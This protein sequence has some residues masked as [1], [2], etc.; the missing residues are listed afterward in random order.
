MAK[1][2]LRT[3]TVED[4]SRGVAGAGGA[5]RAV[6]RGGGVV[7]TISGI[8][9][10]RGVKGDIALTGVFLA[11][12]ILAAGGGVL[13]ALAGTTEQ[14]G[15]EGQQREKPDP[16]QPQAA[17]GTGE[18]TVARSGPAATPDPSLAFDC[19]DFTNQGAAQKALDQDLEDQDA[20]DPDADGDACEALAGPDPRPK[21]DPERKSE[22]EKKSASDKDSA[23]ENRSA[24][25]KEPEKS[26]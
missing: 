1:G 23:S 18:D 5:G 22:P 15:P 17:S 3:G 24:P 19:K 20:L 26:R 4:S 6:L 16:G 9:T 8:R 10:R 21:P 13:V 12:F 11:C 7:I 14:T 25:E 2:V